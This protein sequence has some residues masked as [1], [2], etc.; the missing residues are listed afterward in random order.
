[1]GNEDEGELMKSRF[2][3]FGLGLLTTA[4][5]MTTPIA[6]TRKTFLPDWTFKGS[7]L[8]GWHTLGQA[9]W[10]A[11]NGELVGKPTSPEGGWLVLDKSFQDVEFGADFRCAEGCKTGV[12][13]RA[14]K[15]DSG[16]KGVFVSLDGTAP[17]SYAVTLD[18]SGKE[19]D[20]SEALSGGGGM[21]RFAPGTSPSAPPAAP[22]GDAARAGGRGARGR[23]DAARGG[24]AVAAG[25]A[26]GRAARGPSAVTSV[27]PHPSN[28]IKP[29]DWNDLDVI[30]DATLLRPHVNSSAANGGGAVKDE[31]GS[32]GPI[33]LYVGGTGEVRFRDVSYKDLN[34]KRFPAEKVSSNFRM[35]RLTPFQYSWAQAVA[36]VNHDGK[37]DIIIPPFIYLGP[38]YTTAREFYAAETLNPSTVYPSI[39]VGFAGDFTG[40]GWPDFLSAN[41]G[42]LYVNPKGEPR[43]WDVYPNVVTGTSEISIMKDID[44]DGKPDLVHVNTG[45]TLAYS[46][47]DP[48]NP[49]GKWITTVIS[50]PQSTGGHGIGAGDINGDGK[51]DIVNAYGWWEQPAAGPASGLWKYHPQAFSRWTARASEGGGEMSIFDVNGDK[52]NDVVTA[53]SAHGYGLA[54]FEQKRS[55]SGEISFVEHIFADDMASNNAGGVTFSEPHGETA[56]DV[57]GDG[58]PDFIVGKRL[59]SHHEGFLDPDGGNGAAVLYVYYT[60]RDPKAPGGARMVPELIHNQ[61]GAGSQVLA[62]DIN[63][64]GVTDIVTSGV[65]GGYVF[66]GK[67]RANGAAPKK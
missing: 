10:S 44:G 1:M 3:I 67:P 29:N 51:M 28:A 48:A 6:G 54:W 38:D 58:V 35:H 53:L 9:Q 64:D 20:R 50:E 23:G 52:L 31:M 22:A 59:W 15:T 49:T 47:P 55:S 12:L 42:R 7:T 16:M 56:A 36:D 60:R 24:A 40:D 18:A 8:T 17:T 63:K 19:T 14:E 39:M 46:H 61:S 30:V 43:R 57:D 66:F 5:V 41:G 37:E 62:A 21:A 27:V 32:F 33:A 13:L 45:A 25:A 26:A 34:L 11:V 65:M 4:L 2:V